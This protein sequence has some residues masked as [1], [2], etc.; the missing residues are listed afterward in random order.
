VHGQKI[1]DLRY[2][3]TVQAVE[4]RGLHGYRYCGGPAGIGEEVCG[5]PAVSGLA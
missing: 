5:D 3:Y 2:V 4:I 1:S